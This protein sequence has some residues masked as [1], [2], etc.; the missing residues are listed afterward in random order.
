MRDNNSNELYT[1]DFMRSPYLKEYYDI[2][3]IKPLHIHTVVTDTR[4]LVRAVNELNKACGLPKTPLTEL[5]KGINYCDD[6]AVAREVKDAG[7]CEN[8]DKYSR[9][10]LNADL[11]DTGE[12]FREVLI[13]EIS[14]TVANRYWAMTRK[15]QQTFIEEIRKGIEDN[16]ENRAGHSEKRDGYTEFMCYM[17]T[18]GLAIREIAA[19]YFAMKYELGK[20]GVKRLME[21]LEKNRDYSALRFPNTV[22]QSYNVG[23]CNRIAIEILLSGERGD[24]D[25]P[26]DYR[27]LEKLIYT[28][29]SFQEIIDVGI[30]LAKNRWIP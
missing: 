11:I 28:P 14:H 12:E 25:D 20:C 18:S 4:T 15:E 3:G 10:F 5:N 23:I 21:R 27:Q 9:I 29:Q 8:A 13:H 22:I 1:D 17:L 7:I 24:V 19:C 2:L 16:I 6:D 30:I 26:C